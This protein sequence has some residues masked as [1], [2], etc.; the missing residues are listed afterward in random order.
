MYQKGDLR[1]AIIRAPMV[2]IVLPFIAGL[3]VA[4][5]LILSVPLAWALM[6]LCFATWTFLAYTKQRYGLRWL[7]GASVA[8]SLL[9]FGILWQ[10]L[11]ETSAREDHVGAL[12]NGATGWEVKVMEVASENE[13]T[14]RAWTEVQAAVVRDSIVPASGRLLLTVMKDS[15]RA[16]LA[17]G[18]RLLIQGAAEPIDRLPDPGGFDLR[19]WAS[20]HGAAHEC[21]AATDHWTVIGNARGWLSVFDGARAQVAGWLRDSGLPDRER[22]LVKA[23]LLGARDELD[24]D[25]RTAFVRSGTVHVLAVSGTHVGI[26]YLA[27]IWALTFLGKKKR[28]RHIRGLIALLV[29]WSY[30][31]L[32][33]FAPSVLRATVMFS[34]FTIAETVR[35]QAGSLSNLAASAFLLLLWDPSML[36]QLGFQLSFLAVLGI[37]V[38]HRPITLLW[39]PPNAVMG[40]FWSLVVVSLAAQA[41][42]LPLCLYMFHAFPVWFLPANMVVVGVVGLAVYGG[43][44]LVVLHAVPVLGPILSTLLKWLLLGLGGASAF[45]AGLPGAYPA[46][47]IGFW[48]M[49]GL[50]VLL[51]FFLAW[52][53]QDR[54]WARSA[55]LALGCFLLCSW[56]WTAHQRND[57]RQFVLYNDR[58]V[59]ACGIVQ[60][61]TLTVFADSTTEWTE[62]K[63]S[64]HARNAGVERV[65]RMDGLPTQM[66]W[67]GQH[68]AFVPLEHSRSIPGLIG[69]TKTIVLHGKGWFDRKAMEQCA[70]DTSTTWLLALDMSGSSR[71]KMAAWCEAADRPLY[72]MHDAGAYVRP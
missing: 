57:Q 13:R 32:T 7:T 39:A 67:G 50:Y 2:R 34:L 25:Q 19:Q 3:V 37:V 15:L 40:F 47:R 18:D 11:H 68:Y 45:F 41:F 26:I 31:G 61:R 54:R 29:L 21:F 52:T 33:G 49:I 38:C 6:G 72:D 9:A 17:V 8:M 22:G 4:R 53:I 64:D 16:A 60:G 71:R 23:L 66:E 42:T 5:Y 14:L 28:G 43:I 69:K 48:G 62:R 70:S 58:D 44:L 51:V 55:T 36:G 46:V 10:R 12:A 1:S 65:I 27:V 56:A 63:V 30:A 59:L 35:W 20:T 24:P